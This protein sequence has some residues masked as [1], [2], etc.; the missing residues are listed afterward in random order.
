MATGHCSPDPAPPCR[1]SATAA[2]PPR[3]RAATGQRA[4]L[5]AVRSPS[6]LAGSWWTQV[7]SGQTYTRLRGGA[8]AASPCLP[9]PPDDDKAEDPAAQDSRRASEDGSE[10][11]GYPHF[12]LIKDMVL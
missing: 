1:P 9:P 10:D 7:G 3:P 4:L 6:A 12:D 2:A 5:A 8:A 11:G